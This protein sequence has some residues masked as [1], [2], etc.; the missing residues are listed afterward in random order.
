MDSEIRWDVVHKVVHQQVPT[1]DEAII[2]IELIEI[3]DV[4]SL[5]SSFS[6]FSVGS[7]GNDDFLDSFL[8]EFKIHR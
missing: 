8:L 7:C 3:Q 5:H 1:C 4:D 6:S 2:S